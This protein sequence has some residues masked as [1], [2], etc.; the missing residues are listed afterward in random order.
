MKKMNFANINK[1]SKYQRSSVENVSI[2]SSDG[3]FVVDNKT[4]YKLSVVDDAISGSIH[5]NGYDF[6]KDNTR[7]TR[8]VFNQ[9]P[10]D[11]FAIS[12]NTTRYTT[13]PK[14][15]VAL[16]IEKSFL[17]PSDL[18]FEIADGYTTNDISIIE[19]L[20]VFLSVLN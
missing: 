11:H 8:E 18:Y 3:L 19:D 15:N 2:F 12:T 4:I 14:S 13:G 6:I 9:I 5:I 7:I 1:L 10:A 20:N 17:K 16:I